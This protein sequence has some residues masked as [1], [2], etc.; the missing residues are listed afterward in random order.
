MKKILIY[1]IFIILGAGFLAS[2]SWAVC[3]CATPVSLRGDANDDCLIN[4]ADGIYILRRL[5]Q[6]GE[7][8]CNESNSDLDGNQ[9]VNLSDV[10]YLLS[11]L[12]RSGPEPLP[13]QATTPPR[14]KISLLEELPP[15]TGN[16]LSQALD[17]NMNLDVAGSG[18]FI[19]PLQLNTL[20]WNAGQNPP[21]VLP[22]I[23]GHSF[24]SATGINDGGDVV[25]VSSPQAFSNE[26]KAFVVIKDT[27]VSFALPLLHPEDIS[28][29]AKAIN[30][31]RQVVG[32]SSSK[33]VIWDEDCEVCEL[34]GIPGFLYSNAH[35]INEQGEVAGVFW[36]DTLQLGSQTANVPGY[37]DQSRVPHELPVLESCRIAENGKK[38][39]RA[40]AINNLSVITGVCSEINSDGTIIAHAIYWD[41]E[42]NLRDMGFTGWP[43]D[44]N[45]AGQIVGGYP[46]ERNQSR[47]SAFM[48]HTAYG[49]VDLDRQI[50]E[51]SGWKSLIKA[52][53]INNEGYIIGEGLYQ[54]PVL[55]LERQ[56]G[57]LLEPVK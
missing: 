35:D 20:L 6:G 14:Y 57:F 50:P 43:Y 3:S 48:W 31:R 51:D 18:G 1:G 28:T 5:F 16:T 38:K 23:L 32:H 19:F 47:S 8:F 39:G 45:D 7:P 27:G 11:Y 36:N 4:I 15:V 17:I 40:E 49:F 22:R 26:S 41:T 10:V 55:G 54:D 24:S 2:P 37:W 29:A 53:A 44:I 42:K 52:T 56:I 12:F 30:N 34:G 21:V 25:G 33:A 9:V 46:T 13:V